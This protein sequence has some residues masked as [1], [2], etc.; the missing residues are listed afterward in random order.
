MYFNRFYGS[1]YGSN[2]YDPRGK[3]WAEYICTVC[4]H[5]HDMDVTSTWHSTFQKRERVCPVCKCMSPE[6]KIK[7][8]EK[9]LELLTE[10]KSSI[11]I[12]IEHLLREIEE[13]QGKQ[14]KNA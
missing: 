8:L 11:D 7:N 1:G 13:E 3:V 14:I 9:E 6:D 2:T 4:G 5:T 10:E 12:K